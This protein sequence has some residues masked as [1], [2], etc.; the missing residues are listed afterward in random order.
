MP[1]FGATKGSLVATR[2]NEIR[3]EEIQRTSQAFSS[4][5]AKKQGSTI[6]QKRSMIAP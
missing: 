6:P 3:V 5:P 2:Y 1:V 4:S